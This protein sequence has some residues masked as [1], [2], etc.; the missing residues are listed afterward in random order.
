MSS[1]HDILSSLPAAPSPTPQKR[2]AAIASALERFDENNFGRTQG[3]GHGL[4][5]TQQTASS[6]PP[7]RRRSV[8]PVARYAVA[9]C[10]VALMAG[11]TAWFYVDQT[12]PTHKE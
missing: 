5:L 9:A 4:R 2:Q 8:M 7:S 1:E 11:S 12:Q 3:N 6:N 10:A